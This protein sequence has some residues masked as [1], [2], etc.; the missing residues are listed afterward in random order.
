MLNSGVGQFSRAYMIRLAT[1][2][3]V[4]SNGRSNNAFSIRQTWIA[5][6]K[7]IGRRP[8]LPADVANYAISGSNQISSDPRRVNAAR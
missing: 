7:K 5:V 1:N 8:R 2:P 3:V 6:S 4:C